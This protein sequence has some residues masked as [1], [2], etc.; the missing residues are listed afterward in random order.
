MGGHQSRHGRSPCEANAPG[1]ADSA[2]VV[3]TL[4]ESAGESKN[5]VKGERRGG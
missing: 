3:A 1:S 4:P 5:K 2:S